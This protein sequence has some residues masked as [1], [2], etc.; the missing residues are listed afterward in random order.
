MNVI[1]FPSSTSDQDAL[2]ISLTTAIT[3]PEENSE[4]LLDAL[5]ATAKRYAAGLDA[6]TVEACKSAALRRAERLVTFEDR[7]GQHTA[8]PSR[9]VQLARMRDVSGN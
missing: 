7:H 2:T 8:A 9:E 3:A 5:L 4:F 1:L 6:A